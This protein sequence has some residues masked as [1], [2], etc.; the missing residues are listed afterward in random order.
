M[1]LSKLASPA[2]LLL[3]VVGALACTGG[4][5]GGGDGGAGSSGSSGSTG[6]T[7]T[8]SASSAS[9]SGS[10]A[11]TDT[12][13]SRD[14]AVSEDCVPVFFGDACTFCRGSNASI[15]K[16][17]EGAYQ[18]AANDAYTHCPPLNGGGRCEVPNTVTKCTAKQCEL[19]SCV[20]GRGPP[21]D[22]HTCGD[23]GI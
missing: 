22:P 14:C 15:A 18:T 3:S 19:V 21:V 8:S 6:S 16:S 4:G 23:G 1:H 10:T 2:F 11:V 5:D 17:A 9:S 20:A 7:S 13:F 12:G